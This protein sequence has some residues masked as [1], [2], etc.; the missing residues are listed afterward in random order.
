[1]NPANWILVKEIFQEALELPEAER[2]AFVEERCRGDA[3]VREE[4]ERLLDQETASEGFMPTRAGHHTPVTRFLDEREPVVALGPGAKLGPFELRRELTAGGMGRVFEAVQD[5]PRRVVAVKTLRLEFSSPDIVRRFRMESEILGRLR[6][7]AIAQVYASGTYGEGG[8]GGVSHPYFAMEYVEGARDL[9]RHAREEGLDVR[10]RLELFVQ[11]C[12]AVHYGHQKGVIHRDLKPGNLL[13]NAAG[14]P[15]VIDYG[16]ARAT[17]A[18]NPF[19]TQLTEAGQL[20]GTLP[21]MSPEQLDGDPADVDT[22]SDV[23][24]LGVVFYELLGGALPYDVETTSLHLAIRTILEREPEPLRTRDPSLRGDLEWIAART[25]EKDPNRRYASASELAA[26]IQRHLRSEPVLAGPPS[27]WY[28]LRKFLWRHRVASTATAAVVVALAVG[29]TRAEISRR[30][31]ERAREAESAQRA[32]A[33]ERQREAETQAAIATAHLGFLSSMLR[34]VRP[35]EARGR[36]VTLRE[37]LDEAAAGIGGA[38]GDQ[39]RVRAEVHRTLGE[40]YLSLDR[41]AEARR[42]LEAALAVYHELG[43]RKEAAALQ[44]KQSLAAVWQYEGRVEEAEA[45]LRELVEDTSELLGPDSES[46]IS[47]RVDLGNLVGETGDPEEALELLRSALL[48]ARDTL[49]DDHE[50]TLLARDRL[51][52][53]LTQLGRLAEVEELHRAAL[54]SLVSQHGRDHPRALEVARNLAQFLG[55]LGRTEE[56]EALLEQVLDDCVRVFGEEGHETLLARFSLAQVARL[57]ADYDRAADLLGETLAARLAVS[58][59]DSAE[60]LRVKQVLAIVHLDRLELGRAEEMLREIAR[61]WE[62]IRGAEYREALHARHDLATVLIYQDRL[63][64]AR[65][66]YLELLEP[67][68]RTLGET[69]P[70][71]LVALQHLALCLRDLGQAEEA[72]TLAREALEVAREI[73]GPEHPETLNAMNT[74][75]LALKD[76]G[77]TDEALALQREALAIRAGFQGPDHPDYAVS[78]ANL[79]YAVKAT[80]ATAEPEFAHAVASAERAWSPDDERLAILRAAWSVSLMEEDRDAEAEAPLEEAYRSLDALLGPDHDDTR[81]VMGLL[82]RLYEDLGDTERAEEMRLRLDS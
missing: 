71:T 16:I 1:M 77:R 2:R 10:A 50:T 48:A 73:R 11:I 72:E 43:A 9:L 60:T 21:Y 41:A 55:D 54:E 14:Q 66:A 78:A 51:A 8:E 17:D 7:P 52:F 69:N 32:I 30:A 58:G 20:L 27:P 47:C 19:V 45:L 63:E 25:L 33:V 61:D 56:A 76:L 49:G 40:T 44:I 57:T 24:A 64:E 79:A 26:D 5:Q 38:Y 31:E 39:P 53:H 36:E 67:M 80:G 68:R 37:V 35:E 70:V 12:E 15:K 81:Y 59:P 62:R 74:L 13:V 65:D 82:L 22:R 4:V 34:G 46:A 18:E 6:H 3:E 28:R 23:Y 75:A 42:H 29:W